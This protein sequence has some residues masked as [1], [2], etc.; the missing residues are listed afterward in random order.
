[1]NSGWG[2]LLDTSI[3]V[4]LIRGNP[5]GHHVDATYGIRTSLSRSMISIVTV[6]EVYSLSRQFA[7][8]SKKHEKLEALLNE[9]VWLDINQPQILSAYGEIDHASKSMGRKMGKNDVWIAATA[10]VC[11]AT[12]LTTDTDFDHLHGTWVNR[13]WIDPNTGKAP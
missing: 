8:G 11:G 1:M 10:R 7:W 13:I 2:L 12:L 3:L 6:G 9:L 4:A 5:L